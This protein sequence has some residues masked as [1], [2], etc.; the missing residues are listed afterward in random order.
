MIRKR[1]NSIN[2]GDSLDGPENPVENSPKT[3]RGRKL[4]DVNDRKKPG[5]PPKKRNDDEEGSLFNVA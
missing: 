3:S 2:V 4:E 1:L 5:R